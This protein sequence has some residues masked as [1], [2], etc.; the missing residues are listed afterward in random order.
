MSSATS[1]A[2]S[3]R[4]KLSARLRSRSDDGPSKGTGPRR[5]PAGPRSTT[6]PGSLTLT[7]GEGFFDRFPGFYETSKT[8]PFWWRLNLRHEGIFTQHRDIF[9]GARVL[10]IA[11]H[12]G[13]WSMAALEAGADS[14][15]GIEA[16]PDLVENAKTNLKS[17]GVDESRFEFVAGDVFEILARQD[18]EVDVVMCLGFLYH[19]LRYPEL[20]ARMRQ[21]GARHWLVDTEIIRGRKAQIRIAKENVVRQGN[22]V[23]DDYSYG[24][25]TLIGRPSVRA[26]K[27]LGRANGYLLEGLSD[28]D[29]LMRDN[30][31]VDHMSDYQSGIRTT[32]RYVR[33]DLA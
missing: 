21:T 10:D 25:A 28:W 20:Y 19:T 31:G 32:V 16:R 8:S 4:S 24:D 14:V 29:G 11:S 1:P 27:M 3:R 5:R 13:R 22:A 18:I 9:A 7:Q 12:D 33:E 15:I 30:P 26:M 17:Y 2:E 23:S 6:A